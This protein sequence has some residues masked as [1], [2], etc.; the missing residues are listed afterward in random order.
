MTPSYMLDTDTVS[1]ALRGVGKVG[2]VLLQ[3]APAELC[4]SS[5]T[6]AELRYGA[7]CR[8][9]RKLHELIDTFARTVGVVPFD[10]DAAVHFGRIGAALTANGT[11]IGQMD[12]MIA[13]HA[14]SLDLIL[15]TNNSK[16]FGRVAGLQ[17]ENW[18]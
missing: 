3:K 18:V 12:T 2:V 6:L 11:P 8:G 4:M 5:V 7:D 17:L 14:S 1:F 13:A 15:V 16:H 10:I 9:S